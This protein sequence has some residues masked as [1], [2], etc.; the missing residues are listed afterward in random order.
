MT[1]K[2]S[3]DT[4]PHPGSGVTALLDRRASLIAGGGLLAMSVLGGFG[5]F[6]AV[7]ALVT[8]GDAVRTATDIAASATR[9]RLGIASLL[10]VVVLDIVVGLALYGVFR[11]VHENASRLEAALRLTYAAV[12][13]V[14]ISHLQSA[15]RLATNG[16]DG[17]SSEQAA[18]QALVAID[19]FGDTWDAA[20]VLFGLHLLTLGWLLKRS[21]AGPRW[22]GGLLALAGVGYLVDSTLAVMTGDSS[23]VVSMYTFVGEFA[24]AVWLVVHGCTKTTSRVTSPGDVTSTRSLLAPASS[25]R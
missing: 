16:S 2:P 10:T 5:N 3:F 11:L 15:V 19:A 22:L 6:G 7:E 12:F 1:A 24:L 9:F 17:L 21:G 14:A 13:A 25:P 4:P 8:P 20:L 23:P 18:A